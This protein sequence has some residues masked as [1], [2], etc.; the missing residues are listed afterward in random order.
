[1]SVLTTV[2]PPARGQVPVAWDPNSES[3]LAGYTVYIGTAPGLYGPPTDVGNVTT[4][5]VMNLTKGQTLFFAITAYDTAG[6]QSDYS[7][8]VSHTIN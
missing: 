1:M 2:V 4:V 3:D 5:N 8:E 6:N 7:N